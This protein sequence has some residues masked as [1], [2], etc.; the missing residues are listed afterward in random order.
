[1]LENI[2]EN[3]TIVLPGYVLDE[4]KWVPKLKFPGKYGLL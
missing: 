3:H 4:Q 2:A 1:M